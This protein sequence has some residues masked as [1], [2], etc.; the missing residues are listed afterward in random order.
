M[1]SENEIKFFPIKRR[2]LLAFRRL[3]A[4]RFNG[5]V[6]DI[7]A[8]WGPYHGELSGC[9]VIPLDMTVTPV[10]RVVGSAL[11]LPFQGR[12]F[13]GVIMTETLEHVPRPETAI[14]EAVR[15]LK[16][17]GLLYLTTPQM[18]PLHY[19]PYDYFRYTRY[20]LAHLLESRGFKVLALEPVGGLYTYLF[21]RLG[22]KFIKLLVNLLGLLPKPWR[23]RAAWALGAPVQY[24]F[25]GLS[26]LLDRLAPRDVLGWAILAQLTPGA[27]QAPLPRLTTFDS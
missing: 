17:Q 12:A 26:G 1:L 25:Y 20:G 23:W 6:A 7:G 2:Q 8:G 13:D 27:A 24:F 18:W 10:I 21:T 16:P 5:R 3:A 9:E 11:A 14:A 4:P 19:E 22:E 15:V